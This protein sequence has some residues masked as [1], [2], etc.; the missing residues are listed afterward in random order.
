MTIENHQ[1]FVFGEG[2]S[3]LQTFFTLDLIPISLRINY[4]SEKIKFNDGVFGERYISV[5]PEFIDR[6][7]T[8]EVYQEVID[9]V[10]K[11]LNIQPRRVF[12]SNED[13]P[14]FDFRKD[15]EFYEYQFHGQFGRVYFTP[16]KIH[17]ALKYWEQNK[18]VLERYFDKK[19]GDDMDYSIYDQLKLVEKYIQKQGVFT[20]RDYHIITNNTMDNFIKNLARK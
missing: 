2:E 6:F 9:M 19:I 3:H 10:C 7:Y 15:I 8:L 20:S 18:K 4:N 14:C 17:N 1:I 13:L 12:C 16:C 11:K 5:L